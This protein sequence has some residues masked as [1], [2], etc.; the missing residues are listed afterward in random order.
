MVSSSRIPTRPRAWSAARALDRLAQ[1]PTDG[2]EEREIV[3]TLE[4]LSP[5]DRGEAL[6]LLDAG[7]DRHTV[8]HLV[9]ED[10]DDPG[11]R[12]RA[13]RLID[14]A[15]SFMSAP[16]R[17][18]VSDIDDTVKP[19]SDPTLK[20][21]SYPGARALFRALDEGPQ[22]GR[23]ADTAGDVHFVTARDGLLIHAA[24][25]LDKT[26]IERN[27]I[28]Y[29]KT[30]AGLLSLFGRLGPV[31]EEKVR[32]VR[33]LL[34]R[35]PSRK[36]VLVGD[37]VQADAA[38]YRRI[39]EESPARVEVVLLHEVQGHPA[40][41]DLKRHPAVIV[42]SDYGDAARQLHARGTLTDRQLQAV[43]GEL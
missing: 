5:A 38:V 10:I 13:R 32:D 40:P 14:G 35:N 22:G 6:R 24:G 7:G 12:A 39:L 9:E 30:I 11:L 42:F 29:G 23:P 3:D 34:A 1:G 20:A 17:M 31:E 18:V 15:R 36:A 43:L 2:R 41:R 19:Q 8:A 21:P 26:G 27:S 25:T 37:T 33:A 4:G 28:V 16:G